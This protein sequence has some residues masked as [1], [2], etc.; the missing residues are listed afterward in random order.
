MEFIIEQL[1]L[2]L[3]LSCNIVLVV[4]GW[5]ADNRSAFRSAILQNFEYGREEIRKAVSEVALAIEKQRESEQILCSAYY[6]NAQVFASHV[7][8]QSA[9]FS[10]LLTLLQTCKLQIELFVDRNSAEGKTLLRCMQALEDRYVRLTIVFSG[11]RNCCDSGTPSANPEPRLSIAQGLC[12]ALS[13]ED[14]PQLVEAANEYFWS[15]PRRIYKFRRRKRRPH[16]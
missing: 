14:V 5:W 8:P 10:K 11:L 6:V 3:S 15:E 7:A 4:A 2:M 16:D 13:D 1:P 9:S 12:D